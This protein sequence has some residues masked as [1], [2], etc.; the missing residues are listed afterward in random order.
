MALEQKSRRLPFGGGISSYETYY[1]YED[2]SQRVR[3]VKDVQKREPFVGMQITASEDHAWPPPKG[4]MGDVGGNFFTSKQLGTQPSTIVAKKWE[5][6]A[7]GPQG[8][9]KEV[10]NA[11]MSLAC[12]ITVQFTPEPTPSWPTA[13][14]SS[15]NEITTL[16]ATAISRCSPTASSV[17]LSTAIGELM[18]EG[19]P[20]IMGHT[21]WQE[22]TLAARN[23]GSEYLNVQF[24]WLPLVN[25]V[26]KF[27]ETV[28]NSDSILKQ[29]DTDRGKVVRRRYSFPDVTES[30]EYYLGL[31]YPDG[32]TIGRP[33]DQR[34]KWSVKI[35]STKRRWFSGAFTYGVPLG[36]TSK[37]T[38]ASLAEKADKLLGIS[39]TPDV[40]W[41]LSPWSW[42]I[43]WFTNTGDVLSTA[44]DMASQGL[45]MQYGYLMEETHHKAVYSLTGCRVMDSFVSVPDASLEV[46]TKSRTAANP[47][48]FGITWDGLSTTQ[49]AILAALGISRS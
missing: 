31:Q 14:N 17:E 15:E 46:I 22:R 38:S 34:G 47:F 11:R 30:V 5:T 9:T 24:G 3:E 7:S 42:A 13:L 45:V 1:A 6:P 28:V 36:M 29:Y 10:L 49:V 4:S 27:G 33:S 19:L 25:D 26:T 37:A 43:D 21:T 35:T 8:T 41:N 40:L 39:L 23:A 44:S 12:P 48:G 20:S 32:Y 2:S 16:G 18:K